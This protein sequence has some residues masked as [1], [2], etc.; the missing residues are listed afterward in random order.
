MK[1]EYK[2]ANTLYQKAFQAKKK[3]IVQIAELALI[4]TR[5]AKIQTQIVGIA[6]ALICLLDNYNLTLEDILPIASCKVFDD[7]YNN[8]TPEFQAL[9]QYMKKD[10]EI[11]E[12]E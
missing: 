12:N 8:M 3:D 1:K 2:R 7:N 4:T 11:Q 9:R 6:A 10:W 5:G